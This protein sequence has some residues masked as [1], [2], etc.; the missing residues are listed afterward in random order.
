MIDNLPPK[1]IQNQRYALPQRLYLGPTSMDHE[2][3]FLMCTMAHVH[4]GAFVLDPFVGTGSILIAAAHFGAVTMGADIDIRVSL[5][6][7]GRSEGIFC[8]FVGTFCNDA[9]EL[10]AVDRCLQQCKIYLMDV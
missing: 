9:S 2:M 5:I 6:P 10:N 1:K 7:G 8:N 3:A 4:R